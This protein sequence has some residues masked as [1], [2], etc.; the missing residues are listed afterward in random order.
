M[1]DKD[2][3][4]KGIIEDLIEDFLHFFFPEQVDQIDFGRGFIFLDKELEQLSPQSESKLRHADKLIRA[5]LKNGEEK[6]FLIHVE[7]QGYNDPDFAFRMFQYSYR[8]R[9]RY[10]QS[11]VALAIYTDANRLYHFPEYREEFWETETLYRYRTFI[12]LD[13][14]PLALRHSGNLFGLVMEVARRELDMDKKDDEQRLYI[15]TEMVRH[16][17]RQGVS[18]RKIR[19]LLDF[20]KYYIDFEETAFFNKFDDDIQMITKSRRAM[21]IREAIIEELK[22]KAQ[23]EGLELGLK[24]GREEGREEMREENTRMVISRAHKKGIPVEDIAELV[25]VPVEKAKAIIEELMKG[26]KDGNE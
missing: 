19:H 2:T 10:N 20:I 17:F 1:V 21:G 6:W 18:K 23:E 8:I 15:K 22:R 25:D 26:E 5:F 16:L 4:W 12:V 14:E 24:E 13:H 9:D 7:V 3:L 11:I